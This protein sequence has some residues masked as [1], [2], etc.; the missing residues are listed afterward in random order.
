MKT[1]VTFIGRM[2]IDSVLIEYGVIYYFSKATIHHKMDIELFKLLISTEH[3]DHFYMILDSIARKYQGEEK[4]YQKLIDNLNFMEG[5]DSI[6]KSLFKYIDFDGGF[7]SIQH[8]NI[9]FSHPL[10]F[11]ELENPTLVDRSEFWMDRFYYDRTSIERYR[12]EL[13][14]KFNKKIKLSAQDLLCLLL[15]MHVLNT[16]ERNKILC[17]S[18]SGYNDHLWSANQTGLCIEYDT[19]LFKSRLNLRNDSTDKFTILYNQVQYVENILRY[20]IR[21]DSHDWIGNLVFIKDKKYK[22]ENE[23]RVLY[24]ENYTFDHK[25]E[26]KCANYN[27]ALKRIQDSD[28]G[29]LDFK[30]LQID[31]KYIKNVSYTDYVKD[32]SNLLKLLDE[33]GI[34]YSKI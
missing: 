16:V 29:N 5:H 15:Y 26:S 27:K 14:K 22:E 23:F 8:L 34:P 30:R 18:D 24:T 33:Y 9:Q 10:A 2:G 12:T 19:E 20:P 6:P 17:L 31:K 4:S 3:E 21:M 7:S 13:S 25:P 32:E 1:L 28:K 11:R